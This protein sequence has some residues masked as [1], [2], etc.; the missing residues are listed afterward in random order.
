M[1]SEWTDGKVIYD[2]K[3]TLR[4]TMSEINDAFACGGGICQ[5]TSTENRSGEDT[6]TLRSKPSNTSKDRFK[7]KPE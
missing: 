7:S 5:K 3:V 2:P 4:Q 6:G 1:I